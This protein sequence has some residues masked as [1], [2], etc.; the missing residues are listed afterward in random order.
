M[1]KFWKFWND[2]DSA[3]AFV[4]ASASVYSD[5]RKQ[6]SNSLFG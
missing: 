4:I 5:D 2:P 6:E 3:G 1:Q